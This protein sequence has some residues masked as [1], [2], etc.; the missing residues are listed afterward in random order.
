MRILVIED[1]QETR[2]Y[3]LR[4]LTQAGHVVDAA[5]DGKDGLFLALDQDFDV[6]IIDRMLPGLD[7]IELCRRLKQDSVTRSI[8]IVMVTAKSEE[9][10]VVLGLGIGADDY[11]PK[12]FSPR[13]LL[14]R[15]EAVLRRGSLR[16]ER[17]QTDRVVRDELVIDTARH[18]ILVDGEHMD[19]LQSAAK[20]EMDAALEQ[21]SQTPFPPLE[22]ALSDVQD[23]GDPRSGGR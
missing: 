22:H 8:S 10:D 5:G 12:P 11:V 17:G 21:A 7:G 2:D 4:G 3:L 18:E 13:M 9:S 15:V 1:D 14:A 19:G 16:E 20:E 6:M 23:V